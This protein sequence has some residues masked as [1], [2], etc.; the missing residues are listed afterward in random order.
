MSKEWNIKIPSEYICESYYYL[1]DGK[2][3]WRVTRVKGVINQP[4]LNMW[5]ANVGQRESSKIMHIRQEYGNRF[6]KLAELILK[7]KKIG[8]K[9]Y[10]KE[11]QIDLEKFDEFKLHCVIEIEA[12]EQKL[13]SNDLMIAGTADAILKYKSNKMYLS[14]KAEPKFIESSHVIGDWKTSTGIYP[15]FWL[16]LAAYVF[17]F[18]ELTNIRLDGAFIAQFRDGKIRVEEKTYDELK[19]YFEIMKHCIKVFEYTKEGC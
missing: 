9:N 11:M 3:Y 13:Y 7:D 6:H 18:E 17:I 19:C 15:D 5:R 10:S 2:K 1:I 12:T 16:Q 14:K 4:G 8:I